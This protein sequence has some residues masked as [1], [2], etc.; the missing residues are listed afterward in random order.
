MAL[1][2]IAEHADLCRDAHA[3]DRPALLRRCPA[4]VPGLTKLTEAPKTSR[5]VPEL[6]RPETIAGTSGAF[7]CSIK[8]SK[9]SALV[10]FTARPW[11][12]FWGRSWIGGSEERGTALVFVYDEDCD[13]QA[14]W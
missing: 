7:G 11:P 8:R 14:L 3:R 13:W 10:V 1:A 2:E 5:L 6:L 9:G 4:N 12:D